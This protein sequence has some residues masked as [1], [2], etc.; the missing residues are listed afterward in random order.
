MTVYRNT[1]SGVQPSGRTWSMGLHFSSTASLATVQADWLAQFSSFWTNGSHGVET[2][3]PTGTT[4]TEVKS[5]SLTIVTIGGVDKIR[6]TGIAFDTVALAGTSSNPSLP[7]QNA[8]LVSLRSALPGREGRGRFRLPAPDE[9][10]VT[11]GKLGL[12][13]STRVTTAAAALRTGM[14]AGGHVEII[15]TTKLTKIG[16][17]VGAFRVVVKE[18]TD[19]VIRS[20]RGRVKSRQAE[21][22]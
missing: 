19:M 16:T 5:E 18:E 6:S 15:L 7:D 2:L 14:A 13:P 8:V 22:A 20:V 10:L 3:F 21:Y 12:T 11:T 1:A 4:V 9:T 17:P